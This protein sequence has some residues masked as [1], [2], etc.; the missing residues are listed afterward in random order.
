[1][2]QGTLLGELC[3]TNWQGMAGRHDRRRRAVAAGAAWRHLE[4]CRRASV[5]PRPRFISRLTPVPL[6]LLSLLLCPPVVPARQ[7]PGTGGTATRSTGHGSNKQ[8]THA[9]CSLLSSGP[10]LVMSQHRPGAST[11]PGRPRVLRCRRRPC[12]GSMAA[13]P[14]LLLALLV[15]AAAVGAAAPAAPA[16]PDRVI[17]QLRGSPSAVEIAAVARGT[18]AP[19]LTAAQH[20]VSLRQALHPPGRVATAAGSVRTTSG[21]SGGPAVYAILDGSSPHDKVKQLEL[22]PGGLACLVHG[23]CRRGVWLPPPHSAPTCLAACLFAGA[24]M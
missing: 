4:S 5:R 24:Q 17:V 6:C 1:M 9:A 14:A 3:G 19:R 2:H 20:G 11:G 13:A 18:P 21:S 12:R 7:R 23:G 8:H 10:R 15:A 16:A 22:L